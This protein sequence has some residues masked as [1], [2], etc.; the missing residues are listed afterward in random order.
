MK[1]TLKIALIATTVAAC[2]S[3]QK[4]EGT[5]NIYLDVTPYNIEGTWQLTEWMG[6]P[7]AEGAFVYMELTRQNREFTMYDN[8][9]GT[10]NA[11][12]PTSGIYSI[13]EDDVI[14]GYYDNSGYT[15]W[16]HKYVISELTATSMVW[17]AADNP[18]DISVYTRIDSIPEY[19][20]GGSA[21]DGQTGDADNIA[22]T[23]N[24]N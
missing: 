11:I 23:G 1:H 18:E 14:W 24:N 13:G 12:N 10:S 8:M 7:L 4:D 3:C 16:S 9:L 15:F 2:L 6:S 22:G 19:V 21:S 17:T 5:D 20:T